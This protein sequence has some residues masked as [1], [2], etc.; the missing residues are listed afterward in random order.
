ME[1]IVAIALAFSLASAAAPTA[2]F[3]QQSTSLAG[4]AKDEAKKPYT[5]YTVRARDVNAPRDAAAPSIALDNQGSF[6]LTGLTTKNY[7][8]EL[9]NKDGKVVCT[10]GPFDLSKQAIKSDVIVDCGKVPAAWWLVGAAAA[11]GITAGIVAADPASPS[12]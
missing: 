7:V 5:D 4:T 9:V 2:L 12:R 11:A 6:S 3:A 8:V 10:E 1:R